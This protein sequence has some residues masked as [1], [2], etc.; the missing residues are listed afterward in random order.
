MTI[1]RGDVAPIIRG[2]VVVKGSGNNAQTE[3]SAH[4]VQACLRL[5]WRPILKLRKF[6]RFRGKGYERLSRRLFM[7]GKLG[8]ILSC[9]ILLSCTASQTLVENSETS[10][11]ETKASS[12][13][14]S[15]SFKIV[16]LERLPKRAP[17]Y[18]LFRVR[19]VLKKEPPEIT[20]ANV[21][22]TPQS[23]LLQVRT[24]AQQRGEQSR[25]GFSLPF[26][27]RGTPS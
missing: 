27:V 2:H 7:V 16:E 18:V 17:Q 1:A 14:G 23:L 5:I 25:W 12:A 26:S 8:W 9:L 19:A 13:D 21:R 11:S 15:L 22:A 20:E 3:R 6:K 10:L 4:L 24:E